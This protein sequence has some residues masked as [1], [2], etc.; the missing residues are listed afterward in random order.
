MTDT[1]QYRRLTRYLN[2]T[3]KSLT[4]ACLDLNINIDDV[5]D[6]ELEQHISECSQCGAWGTD[7]RHDEDD[8][9]ICKIC[10]NLMGR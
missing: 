2:K 6:Y 7:H 8:F 3:R 10:F 4:E 5:D 1:N 9:L